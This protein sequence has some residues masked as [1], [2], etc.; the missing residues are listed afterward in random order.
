MKEQINRRLNKIASLMD[1]H[2]LQIS[3]QGIYLEA[4][5]PIDNSEL[6][7]D[8]KQAYKEAQRLMIYHE[9]QLEKLEEEKSSLTY[10]KG[11]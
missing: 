4:L 7:G 3:I 5:S 8:T 9:R 11:E 6:E 2:N 10:Q 1:R